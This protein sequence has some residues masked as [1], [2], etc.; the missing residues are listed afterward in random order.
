MY[1]RPEFYGGVTPQN[2]GFQLSIAG[3]QA[4][5]RYIGVKPEF[6]A[7]LRRTGVKNRRRTAGAIS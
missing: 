6:L 3:F 1:L 7:I 5:L 2:S 4:F